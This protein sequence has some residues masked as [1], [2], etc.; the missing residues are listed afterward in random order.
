MKRTA[1]I[2][3]WNNG[4]GLSRDIQL[5][6]NQLQSLGWTVFVNSRPFTENCAKILTRAWNRT[7]RKISALLSNT[8]LIPPAFDVNIHL[9][10][11]S[12]EHLPLS[13]RNILVPNQEWFR[14]HSSA[15]LPKIQEVWAKTRLAEQ[16][17]SSLCTSV[18]MLGWCGCDH[19]IHDPKV[20]QTLTALHIAGAS[21]W[22]GTEAVLDVWGKHP[23]WPLLTILRK[24]SGYDGRPL[25]W[26][27]HPDRPNIKIISEHMAEDALIRLQNECA[28]HLCPSEAEGFGHILLESMSIGATII[29]TDAP[30]MNELVTPDSGLLTAVTDSEPMHLG[31]RY[32]VSQ[33]ELESKISIALAMKEHERLNLSKAARKQF[34]C[35]NSEF[36]LHLIEFLNQPMH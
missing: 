27:L 9:E 25:N 8:H 20:A 28:I 10:D 2:I 17:F 21:Q 33:S 30:P 4:G 14:D 16:I 11:I 1:N 32:F 12:P 24:N 31:R 23:D 7:H 34:D 6:H 36:R 35:I 19:R 26:P 18:R 13:K 22:K 15:Q 29:T 5:L 3:G